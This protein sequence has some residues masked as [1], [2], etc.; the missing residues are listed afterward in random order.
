MKQSPWNLICCQPDAFSIIILLPLLIH[1]YCSLSPSHTPRCLLFIRC[2]VGLR[3]PWR[4]SRAPQPSAPSASLSPSASTSFRCKPC[5]TWCLRPDTCPP[6]T[7]YDVMIRQLLESSARRGNVEKRHVLVERAWELYIKMRQLR[8]EEECPPDLM[9]FI[10]EV[11][12]WCAWWSVLL[13]R[14]LKKSH[15]VA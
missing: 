12:L 11:R 8:A 5:S 1:H 3:M 6:V 13:L 15:R 9:G 10:F 14:L 7:S 2:C 4:T